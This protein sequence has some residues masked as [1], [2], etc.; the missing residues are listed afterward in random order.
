MHPIKERSEESD[1]IATF[2]LTFFILRVDE[3]DSR[4][5]ER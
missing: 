4:V 5:N 2:V 1:G 3:R